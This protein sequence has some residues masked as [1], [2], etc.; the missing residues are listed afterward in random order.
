MRVRG[1]IE[2]LEQR[3][4]ERNLVTTC[5]HWFFLCTPH[6][7]LQRGNQSVNTIKRINEKLKDIPDTVLQ[8]IYRE[9]LLTNRTSGYFGFVLQMGIVRRRTEV[10]C[11]G[12]ATLVCFLHIGSDSFFLTP[13]H[14]KWL[15]PGPVLYMLVQVM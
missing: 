14:S 8:R 5:E 2:N 3:T 6:I 11:E 13:L 10:G 4:L 1:S 15:E 9:N 7:H 12:R